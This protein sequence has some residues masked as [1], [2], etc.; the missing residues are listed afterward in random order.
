MCSLATGSVPGAPD[1]PSK[2]RVGG[3][4]PSRG[5]RT[6]KR[7]ER[8]GLGSCRRPKLAAS[9]LLLGVRLDVPVAAAPPGVVPSGH[10]PVG[11]PELARDVGRADASREQVTRE[12]VTQ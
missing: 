1:R 8:L 3:S 2:Q 11:V 12:G 9:L 6:P 10:A 4:I 5:T 7:I